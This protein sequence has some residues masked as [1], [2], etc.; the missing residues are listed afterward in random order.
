MRSSRRLEAETLRNLEAIWLT[1]N[2]R[3]DHWTIA[4]F[5]R[6]HRER[7]KAVLREF[8][9]VCR[10]LE[11]F[12]AELVAIDGAKFKAVNRPKRHYTADQ[13]A[14]LIVHIDTRIEE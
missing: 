6:A 11:L 8:N 3:P 10:K 5:R 14:E 7:F 1:G 2:L 9:L 12:G 13:L 4:A